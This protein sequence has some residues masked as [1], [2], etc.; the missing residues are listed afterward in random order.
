MS[1]KRVEYTVLQELAKQWLDYAKLPVMEE[2]RKLW[3]NV[4]DL[5]ADRPPILVETCMLE[6]YIS[7]QELQCEDPYLRN[8]EKLMRE[9]LQ[10]AREIPDDIVIEPC[11]RIPWSVEISDYGVSLAARHARTSEGSDLGYSFDFP[12]QSPDDF[13]KL[14]HRRRTVD[15]K[16]SCHRKELLGNI[17]GGI[18]PVVMGGL[19]YFNPDPGYHPWVGNLY[20]GL[21]QDLFKL[22][23]NENLFLW[24]CDRP[25]F[26]HTLMQFLMED[27]IAHLKWMEEEQLLYLNTG[28]WNPCPGSYGFTS[29]LP[30]KGFNG[31]S[32]KLSDCWGWMESQESAGISPQMLDELFLPYMAEVS[33]LFGL[34][35]Y[36]CCEGIDDRLEYIG[37]AIPNLRAVSVSGWNDM[38]RVGEL[39]G[40]RYVFSRKP[41]PAYISGRYPDWELL[42]QDVQETLRGGRD[43]CIEF[44]FRDIYTVNGDRGRLARWVEMVRAML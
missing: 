15:R 40:N 43:C 6:D 1:A 21:T 18:L 33:R 17:F 10:H 3:K 27:R 30:R 7:E 11:F 41:V 13:L 42:E 24:T 44:C 28:T 22:I 26:L 37:R 29:D 12:I 14:R 39:L 20:G 35:Y 38:N 5:K 32:V 34:T 2:R 36:G 4:K 23:G 16:L 8:V 25:E 9:T 31:K 19:D